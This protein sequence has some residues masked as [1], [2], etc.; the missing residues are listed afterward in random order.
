MPTQPGELA[1]SDRSAAMLTD[2]ITG[3]GFNPARLSSNIGA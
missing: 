1:S 2:L 3:A